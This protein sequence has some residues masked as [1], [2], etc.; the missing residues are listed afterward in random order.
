MC[1]SDNSLNSVLSYFYLKIYVF[2]LISLMDESSCSVSVLDSNSTW[3]S[4]KLK[5]VIEH[6]VHSATSRLEFFFLI[7]IN[8]SIF[9]L[10][11]F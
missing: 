11:I 7:I 6:Q 1:F 4:E 10:L 5:G 2:Y 3:E 9:D 8:T